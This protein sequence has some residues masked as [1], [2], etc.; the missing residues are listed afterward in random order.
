[1]KIKGFQILIIVFM[2][3]ISA[4]IKGQSISITGN[5]NLNIPATSITEAGADFTNPF[6]SSGTSIAIDINVTGNKKFNV[7]VNKSDIT[8]NSALNL[9]VTR[10]TNGGPAGNISGGTSPVAIDNTQ[11]LFFNGKGDKTG[12]QIIYSLSGVSVTL[13]A[14]TYT[15]TV[16]Y[17]LF[18]Q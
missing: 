18:Q 12:I 3:I 6:A 5:W 14:A 8:W 9:S 1:M 15:T 10:T 16:I 13:P 17:T 2:V 7:Y 4:S 11:T